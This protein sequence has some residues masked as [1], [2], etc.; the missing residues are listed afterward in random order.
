MNLELKWL[1]YSCFC[2][3]D[4]R[5]ERV[6]F[7]HSLPESPVSHASHITCETGSGCNTNFND[8]VILF[9]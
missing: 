7:L 2:S 8:Y 6:L 4:V 1:R 9:A 3:W 5:A